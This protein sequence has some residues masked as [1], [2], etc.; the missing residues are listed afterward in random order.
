MIEY[1]I[2]QIIAVFFGMACYVLAALGIIY[3][4]VQQVEQEILAKFKKESEE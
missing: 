3:F 2:G 1:L 4:A